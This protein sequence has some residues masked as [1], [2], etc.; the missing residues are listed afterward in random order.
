M[1]QLLPIVEA[2][3][4]EAVRPMR[5]CFVRPA[6]ISAASAWAAPFAPPL[7]MAYVAAVVREHGHKVSVIDAAA[8]GLDH[9][10]L[11]DGYRYQGLPIDEIVRRI[12]PRVEVIAL[13]C[14]FSIEWPWSRQ[15]INALREAF[16]TVPIVAGGEHLTALPEFNLRDCRALSF[17]VL[18]EGEETMAELVDVLSA[19]GDPAQVTGL[20]FLDANDEYVAT[21]ARKRIRAVDDVPRPAWDLFPVEAYLDNRN[22]HGVYR[23]RS[24]PVLATRGCPYKCTFCS[25]PVMYGN[26]WMA[27]TPSHVLDE[28]EDHI[29]QYNVENIDF[30]DL[31]FVLRRSWILE[32]CAEIEKRG[33]KFTWQLPSG[34]RSEVIDA[35]V[36]A[37]L[38]RTGCRNLTYAPESGSLRTL[39]RIKKQIDPDR[40]V[41][42]IRQSVREGI[43]VKCTAIIGFPDETRTD[44]WQT[45]RFVWRL[46]RAGVYDM[47]I[48]FF[49]PYPGSALFQELRDE[50][51]IRELD[52]RY[53]RSLMAFLNPFA[54][55]GYCKAISARELQFWRN[56]GLLSFYSI[57]YAMRPWR[58]LRLIRN[59]ARN[60]YETAT[61]QRVA[62]L[63]RR[64]KARRAAAAP[65]AVTPSM[66]NST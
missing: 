12:D 55:S 26:L 29:R 33:L 9:A 41:A 17:C 64:Q 53:F 54:T 4:R 59:V 27:R 40:M 31:T 42:S 8:E 37:A 52:D 3:R 35:E 57:S 62:V 43:Q 63:F 60:R 50:G 49:S 23:G 21:P 66:S 16:P 5:V 61:E 39:K 13:S 1:S 20:A 45:I 38:Y 15:L 46:A 19:E 36:S 48:F 30:Y 28:I 44:V 2:E 24:M 47:P 58:F 7:G 18:G 32:F 22:G 65:L 10:L 14:M 6:V 11:T 25:N 34:T 56:F 51:V